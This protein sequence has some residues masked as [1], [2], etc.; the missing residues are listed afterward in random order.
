MKI[1]T[2]E[3]IALIII[4]IGLLLLK[5]VFLDYTPASP[6][7]E[8]DADKAIIK[9]KITKIYENEKTTTLYI[10]TCEEIKV[11]IKKN[12]GLKLNNT[13]EATGSTYK[14]KFYADTLKVTQTLTTEKN[15]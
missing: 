6:I 2:I 8:K 3:I 7:L 13:I 11:Q 10:H 14:G 1:N 15:I 9:G 12:P 5:Y 4:L